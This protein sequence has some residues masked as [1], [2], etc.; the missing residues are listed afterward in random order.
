MAETTQ[1]EASVVP[2]VVAEPPR[3]RSVDISLHEK[4]GSGS[5]GTVFRA[6]AARIGTI[7]V[8]VLPW[9]PRDVSVELKRELRLMQRCSSPYVVRAYGAFSKPQELWIV[10]EHCD[11]GSLLDVIRARRSALDEGAIALSCRDALRGLSY[12]HGY[13]KG[14]IHRDI[15]CANLLL[16]TA[17]G[18]RVKLADFG[19]SVQLNST[20]SRRQSVIGTPHWMAPEVV[21]YGRYDTRADV[22]SLGITAIEMAQ[23]RPPRYGERPMLRVMLAITANPP[24]TL[25][26]P[27]R[28]SA[29]LN[30]FLARCLVKDAAARPSSDELLADPFV[31][32]IADEGCLLALA[33]AAVAQVRAPGAVAARGGSPGLSAEVTFGGTQ[34]VRHGSD[35]DAPPASST[36][37]ASQP[38]AGA[39]AAVNGA[40]SNLARQPGSCNYGLDDPQSSSMHGDGGT[41][42]V[43]AT[44]PGRSDASST[45]GDASSMHGDGGTF[46]VHATL[47]GRSAGTAAA[48]AAEGTLVM[49]G[50]SGSAEGTARSAEGTLVVRG[51]S[52][53]A[54]PS[55]SAAPLPFLANLPPAPAPWYADAPPGGGAALPAARGA[56]ADFSIRSSWTIDG[57]LPQP[58]CG[59]TVLPAAAR[60]GSEWEAWE[61]LHYGTASHASANAGTV[62][63]L[64]SLSV[65]LPLPTSS[66][67]CPTPSPPLRTGRSI[68]DAEVLTISRADAREEEDSRNDPLLGNM[69]ARHLTRSCSDGALY[70]HSIAW[71]ARPVLRVAQRSAAL[72]GLAP[73]ALDCI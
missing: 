60:E 36:A 39:T 40:T 8:K 3:L 28:A 70:G 14:I 53:S 71:A 46:V 38:A 1:R 31:S 63:S 19:V 33:T 10:M 35:A 64:P 22:W 9:G 13:R 34:T 55:A 21:G 23:G 24:P 27:S 56:T 59:R 69:P 11:A 29:G 67:V 66:S 5:F 62:A 68:D 45:H 51:P 52:G 18:G 32:S 49:R 16:T 6:S 17:Q 12:M 50:P 30:E 37:T 73:A 42:V 26:E 47:P 7:A 61:H 58:Q 15:K 57:T 44:L 65:P 54:T 4:L 2:P 48:V 20:A 72:L 43:H 25:A 41:V